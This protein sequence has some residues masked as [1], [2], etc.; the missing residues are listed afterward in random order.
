MMVCPY[1]ESRLLLVL[2]IDHSRVAG[3]VAAHWGNRDFVKL[4]PYASMVL[5][6]QEHD[7]GW[8]DWE[9]K[10]TL[11]PEG[12][13]TDYIGSIR[14]LGKGVWLGFY[15]NGIERLAKRDPY[16]AYN[17]SM[18]GEGLLTQGKGL[19]PYM[20]DY[21]VDAE[22]RDYISQQTAF[23]EELLPA[24]RGSR[25]WKEFSTEEHLWIN[26]K[27][28]EVFDQLAQY[29]CN[30]YPFN[31]AKRTNGPSNKLSNTP[32][33]VS[34]GENDTILS[35]DVKDESHATVTPYP[36][37]VNPLVVSFPGRLIANRS[38]ANH[39]EFL[40]DFYSG[41]RVAITYYLHAS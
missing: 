31:S 21:T 18:H 7:S 33:P 23:R 16:A 37:D 29:V 34:P 12:Y 41:E 17:V 26:F 15:R 8:W 30:R 2:Q 40:R 28:M 6:A 3:F 25:Q 10:P 36:F 35:V 27:Y 22:V 14:K 4:R 11:D 32:V 9:I 20:P 19:L 38:Y 5:A 1:D 24:M 13:P 39:E